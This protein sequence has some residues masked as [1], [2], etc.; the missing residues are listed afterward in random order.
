MPPLTTPRR[1]EESEQR[2][3]AILQAARAVFSRQGYAST[4]VEDIASQAGIGKGTLYLYFRSKE[5]IYMA[6]VLEIAR[7]MSARSQEAMQ[8]AANW[9]DKVR[10][11][12]NVRLRTVDQQKDFFRIFVTEVRNMCLLDKP[13]AVEFYQIVQEGESQLAQIFAVAAAKG[14]IRPVDPEL[15]A[16]I[17][18]DLVRGL[19]ER[20]VR[21]WGHVTTA[22]DEEYVL[23]LLCRALEQK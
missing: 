16:L 19:I 13:L 11:F 15:T 21:G 10:A 1:K 5:Q 18:A 23:D 3:E 17:V 4:V 12:V 22:A 14:E 8:A 9:Q 6:A 7:E 20:R 2:R